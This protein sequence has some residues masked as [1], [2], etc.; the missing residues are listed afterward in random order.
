[1]RRAATAAGVLLMATA[2]AIFLAPAGCDGGGKPRH[3]PQPKPV[4]ADPSNQPSV[5]LPTDPPPAAS[6]PAS[7]ATID[8]AVAAHTG[9]QPAKLD[10]LR[11]ARKVVAGTL[12]GPNGKV[13][14]EWEFVWRWPDRVR[15]DIRIDGVPPGYMRRVGPSAWMSLMGRPEEPKA[16]PQLGGILAESFAECLLVLVPF[17]DP[18]A[19][20]SPA[21][22]H[23]VRG[24]PAVGVR[25]TGPSWPGAVCH[26]D[27]DTRRL[28]QVSYAGYEEG[29]TVKEVTALSEKAFNGVTVP[30]RLAIRWNGRE[31]GEWT[32]KSLDFPVPAEGKLFDGP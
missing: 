25:V 6:D 16:D 17:A 31:V 24:K 27:P 19:V 23:P 13:G 2:G 1:M 3:I 20:Y 29:T 9:N 21:A 4:P 10:A 30:E 15:A 28:V 11:T 12:T 22:G 18:Q 8:A 7:K 32:L 5:A 26:F 14:N